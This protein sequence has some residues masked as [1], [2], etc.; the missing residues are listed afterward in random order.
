MKSKQKQSQLSWISKATIT[1][2][3]AGCMLMPASAIRMDL[4]VKYVQQQLCLSVRVHYLLST[5]RPSLAILTGF[6]K[7]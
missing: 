4:G 3:L 1:L 2:A 6:Q 7:Y 5:E